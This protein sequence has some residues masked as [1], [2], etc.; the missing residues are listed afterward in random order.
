M[1]TEVCL[2]D[3]RRAHIR[4]VLPS[5]ARALSTA[6]ANADPETLRLRF[7]GWAPL[8]DDATVRRLVEVDYQWRLALIAFDPDDR[9]I[10]IARYE[11]RSGGDVAEIAVAVDPG[12]RRVGLG[13]RLLT[14]LGEAAVARGIRRLVAIYLVGNHDVE[15]LLKECGL[16]CSYHV[17][18][19]LVE[20]ELLLPQATDS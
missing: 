20:A 2:G 1:D 12:W 15:G 10:G 17:S 7:L 8:L 3:R 11:S 16:S 19:G 5:D 4:P 14:M 13:S 9:G 18:Q 6:I